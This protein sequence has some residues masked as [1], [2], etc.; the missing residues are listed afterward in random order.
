M[1]LGQFLIFD[2]AEVPS[3]SEKTVNEA[4]EKS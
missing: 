3:S 4:L 1:S 2:I